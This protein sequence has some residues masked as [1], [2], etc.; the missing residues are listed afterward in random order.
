VELP[1]KDAPVLG[2]NEPV[3][4]LPFSTWKLIDAEPVLFDRLL[5]TAVAGDAGPN[6][7]APV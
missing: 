6:V 7:V 2:V 1:V 4:E 3:Q 5:G